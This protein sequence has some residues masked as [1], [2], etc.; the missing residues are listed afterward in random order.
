M[1]GY[2]DFNIGS[3]NI[4]LPPPTVATCDLGATDI[5]V[6][7]DP[8]DTSSLQ[9]QGDRAGGQAFRSHWAVAL[10]MLNP[11]SLLPTVVTRLTVPIY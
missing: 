11:I 7:L 1:W 6:A 9:T 5:V 3:T 10:K 2:G 4:V 8:I